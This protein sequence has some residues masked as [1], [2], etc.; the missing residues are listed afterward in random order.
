M[1]Q[2]HRFFHMLEFCNWLLRLVRFDAPELNP[3]EL[4]EE[5]FDIIS[6]NPSLAVDFPSLP[7][8][9]GCLLSFSQNYKMTRANMHG[10]Y[11]NA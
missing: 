5:P 6:N 4:G 2:N 1:A 7:T 11:L 8:L 10:Y 9:W 3:M